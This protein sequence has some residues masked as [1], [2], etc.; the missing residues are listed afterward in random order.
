MIDCVYVLGKGSHWDN[1][2]IRYSLR[3]IEK[4]LV[5][6][7]NI[8]IVGELPD[9]IQGVVHIPCIDQLKWKEANIYNKILTACNSDLVSDQFLFFNDDHFLNHNFDAPTFPFY[10]KSDIAVP[11]QRLHGRSGYRCSVMNTARVLRTHNLSTKYFD[12]HT[13]IIYDK[14]K[15]IDVM[16]RYDWNIAR[17]YV[18]KSLYGN[19]LG[20]EGVLEPDCKINLP[21]PSMETLSSLIKPRKVWSIGN[22]SYG[23][24]LQKLLQSL[25]PNPS[26][27]E[28]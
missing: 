17:G 13:P 23:S 22:H 25:Y 16:S 6:Y 5:N 3:S 14:K 18:I 15:F 2:E 7:R 21:S 4:H 12:T 27:W 28:K 10:Y 1:N 24:G 9:F 20:I 8:V 11:L 19:T 26:K